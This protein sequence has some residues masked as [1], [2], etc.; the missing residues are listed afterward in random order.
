MIPSSSPSAFPEGAPSSAGEEETFLREGKPEF[1]FQGSEKE[2]EPP[3]MAWPP[4]EPHDATPGK[5]T[6]GAT[7]RGQVHRPFLSLHV[8]PLVF[9]LFLEGSHICNSCRAKP[10]RSSTFW[11]KWA[12]L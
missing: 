9:G 3:D 8:S 2:G 10:P 11:V 1:R 6:T 4:L 7:A 5:V 12:A